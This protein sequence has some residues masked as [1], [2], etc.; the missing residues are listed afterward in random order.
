[1]PTNKDENIHT[2]E[3]R[4]EKREEHKNEK[5]L[6]VKKHCKPLAASE[7]DA[8]LS[9]VASTECLSKEKETIVAIICAM[10]LHPCIA[11]GPALF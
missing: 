9:L 5:L 10:P 6:K 2:Q 1:M 4:P 3:S 7:A 8:V 11:F